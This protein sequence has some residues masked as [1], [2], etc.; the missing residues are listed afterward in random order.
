[1]AIVTVCAGLFGMLDFE[2]AGKVSFCG[3]GTSRGSVLGSGCGQDRS[4]TP[5]AWPNQPG[6]SSGGYAQRARSHSVGNAGSEERRGRPGSDRCFS[7]G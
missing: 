3:L 4:D 5:K 6:P 2:R 1:M 7:R